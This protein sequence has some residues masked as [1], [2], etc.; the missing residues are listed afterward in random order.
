MIY[1]NKLY[2]EYLLLEGCKDREFAFLGGSGVAF[3]GFKVKCLQNLRNGLKI[4]N[5]GKNKPNLYVSVAKYKEI[6]KF[7]FNPKERRN[8]TSVWFKNNSKEITSFDLF[9]ILI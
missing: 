5:W 9:L 1:Y 8:E 4:V 6:P 7:T 3:R 2:I